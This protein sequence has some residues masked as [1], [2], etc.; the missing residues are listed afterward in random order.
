VAS[1]LQQ[2]N[3]YLGIDNYLA[4]ILS[5]YLQLGITLDYRTQLENKVRALSLN[6][7]NSALKKYIDLDKLTLIY[8]GDFTKK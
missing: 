5:R 7:V 8:A 2:R 6:D 4:S 3:T 1:W